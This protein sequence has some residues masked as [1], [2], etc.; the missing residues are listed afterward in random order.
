MQ[1]IYTVCFF[2]FVKFYDDVTRK[3]VEIINFCKKFL[4][5]IVDADGLFYKNLIL[6][7]YSEQDVIIF[8]SSICKTL[9]IGLFPFKLLSFQ[10]GLSYWHQISL[11]WKVFWSRLWDNLSWNAHL[12]SEMVRWS[13][14]QL[15][16]KISIK[17]SFAF[18]CNVKYYY[19]NVS[20]LVFLKIT[21]NL[22]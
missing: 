9:S 4:D 14:N 18:M 21:A 8:K 15:L 17:T 2:S 11:K 19:R 5:G 12:I 6:R 20:L 13:F 3:V 16:I 1:D 7:T 22:L 10:N